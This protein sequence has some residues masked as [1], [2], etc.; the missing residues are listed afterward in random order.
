MHRA[1]TAPHSLDADTVEMPAVGSE[2]AIDPAV[3]ALARELADMSDMLEEVAGVLGACARCFGIDPQCPG[4]RGIG[5]PGHRESTEP[6]LLEYWLR[7]LG[8]G[9]RSRARSA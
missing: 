8:R 5:S 2:Y 3:H 6:A 9:P 1:P 7:A 4:C